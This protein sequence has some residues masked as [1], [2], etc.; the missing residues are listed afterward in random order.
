[1]GNNLSCFVNVPFL[2]AVFLAPHYMNPPDVR[3]EAKLRQDH[4]GFW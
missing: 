4:D 2:Y 1:M 3:V